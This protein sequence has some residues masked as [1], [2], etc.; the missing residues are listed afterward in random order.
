MSFSPDDPHGE[1]YGR[2][3]LLANAGWQVLLSAGVA[4]IALGV[5]VLVW[6][7]RTLTVVGVLFGIY[8]LAIGAFQLAGAFGAHIPGHMRVLG[9]VSGG[10]CVLLGL[11]CFRGPAQSLLLLALWIGFGWLMRGVMLTGVALSARVLPARGWQ[12]FLG[13]VNFLAGIVLIVS[14][15]RSLGVLALVAGI[16][17]IVM[18]VVEVVHAIRLRKHLTGRPASGAQSA[19]E[20]RGPGHT[21]HLRGVA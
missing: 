8:L 15:F 21:G 11:L 14:P 16:L 13:I 6:P 10:L 5:V 4:S 7:A 20:G 18:G 19:D 2:L 12:V 1:L 17:L 3:G 9:F